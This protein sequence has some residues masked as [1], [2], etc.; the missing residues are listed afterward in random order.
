MSKVA[1]VTDSNSGISQSLA[2]EMGVYVVPMPFMIDGKE[3]YE[4][5]NLTVDEFYD[6]LKADVDIS[7]SQPAIDY[8]TSLW[9]KLLLEYDE[10]VHIPMSS[11]LSSS[12]ETAYMLA[13]DYDG[14]VKVVDN[15]RISVTLRR[16]IDDALRMSKEGKD[17]EYIKNVLTETKF[18]ASIYITLSTLKYLKKGGRLTPAAAAI[19]TILRIKPVLQIQGERL[20]A[21]AKARTIKNAK[22]IM[23]KAIKHD[24]E[25]RLGKDVYLDIAHTD[26]Y[27]EALKFKEEVIAEFPDVNPDDIRIDGLSL[28]VSCHIGEGSIALTATKKLK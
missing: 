18:D 19:G 7:T 2:K 17:A 3:Y 24:M 20:D 12:C 16:S 9:D 27:E 22:E 23:I 1:I 28:S 15:Q 8:V 25:T 21:F 13:Q 11:G 10:I 5:I 6:K 26:N 4:D 14:K